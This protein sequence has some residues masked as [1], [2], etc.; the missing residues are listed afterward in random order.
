MISLK[1]WKE[2][3]SEESIYEN[4]EEIL[5]ALVFSSDTLKAQKK[6]RSVC[7]SQF[8]SLQLCNKRKDS[9]CLTYCEYVQFQQYKVTLHK[10]ANNSFFLLEDWLFKNTTK[11]QIFIKTIAHYN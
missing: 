2:K 6:K 5:N 11:K 7:P 4:L 9:L 10:H 8:M 3:S 1:P